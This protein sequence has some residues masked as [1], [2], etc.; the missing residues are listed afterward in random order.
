MRGWNGL[1]YAYYWYVYFVLV[2]CIFLRKFVANT[3]S[4]GVISVRYLC[5]RI[6]DIPYIFIYTGD[7]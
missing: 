7:V 5:I 3:K 1:L 6:S 2:Y 4:L